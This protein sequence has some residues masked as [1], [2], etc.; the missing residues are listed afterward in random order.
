MRDSGVELLL[1]A[2]GDGTARD[3]YD[4]IGDELPMVG[5]PA[6]VKMHS[7]VFAPSPE[8]AAHAGETFL[9]L[10]ASARLRDADIADVDEQA[11]RDGRVASIL[12]GAARVPDL[13]RLVLPMKSG[14]RTSPGADLEALCRTVAADLEPDTL[15]LLGPGTTTAAVLAALGLSQHAAR[16]RRD[17]E[18]A[19]GRSRPD[20][21]PAGGTARSQRPAAA[22]A[23]RSI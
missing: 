15:Y 2:G 23:T 7:G 16:R 11:A 4:A 1:F 19:A 20:R 5:I 10:G 13:P 6:G 18:R 8:A 9:R 3:I 17:Q 12:Y 14:S 21:G 22:T